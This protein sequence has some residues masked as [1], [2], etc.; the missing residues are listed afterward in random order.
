MR[1]PSSPPP[2]L[3]TYDDI[4]SSESAAATGSWSCACALQ[5]CY[6]LSADWHQNTMSTSANEHDAVRRPAQIAARAA[7][8]CTASACS[9]PCEC[10]VRL[11]LFGA[12]CLP[13]RRDVELASAACRRSPYCTVGCVTRAAACAA[14]LMLITTAR[15]PL[16]ARLCAGPWCAA[17]VYAKDRLID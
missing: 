8:A 12:A 15:Y 5:R 1:A 6:Q 3:A 11:C 10:R 13:Y 9:G 14:A 7:C 2:L 16:L 17:A 4:P